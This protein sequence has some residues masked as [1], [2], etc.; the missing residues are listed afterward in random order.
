MVMLANDGIIILQDGRIVMANPAFLE[1]MAYDFASLEG[2]L[3]TDLLDPTT[4]HQFSEHYL[5]EQRRAE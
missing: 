4:A 3:I 2:R 5:L 1:M